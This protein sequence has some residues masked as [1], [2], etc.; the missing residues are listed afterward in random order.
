MQLLV[1]PVFVMAAKLKEI[2]SVPES[3]YSSMSDAD[4][5][6]RSQ[7]E[8]LK[9]GMLKMWRSGCLTFLN[10][11]TIESESGAEHCSPHMS[12]D[13]RQELNREMLRVEVPQV[14]HKPLAL[15]KS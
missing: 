11:E 13:K 4:I 5:I 14:D 10:G 9:S 2:E 3:Q 12:V 1:L 7:R 8:F 15:P 6:R